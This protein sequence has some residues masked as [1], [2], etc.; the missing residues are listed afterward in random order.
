MRHIWASLT[1]FSTLGLTTVTRGE[2]VQGAYVEARSTPAAASAVLGERSQAVLAWQV[3]QGTY[4]GEKLDGQTIVAVVTG[5]PSPGVN[6]GHTKTVFVVDDRTSE[7]T[8]QAL[9]H[10][11][12]DLATGVIHDAGTTLKSKL[13]VRVAEGCGCGAAVIEC[14]LAKVRT[15]RLTE[16]DEALIGKGLSQKP[17][18]DVFS[19][20]PA[21]AT[22]FTVVG[23]PAPPPGGKTVMTFTGSFSR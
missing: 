5:E 12:R 8:Q 2:S 11:A 1:V 14:P 17:L 19:S 6:F 20:N 4:D 22:E 15:R 9:V 18:G 10:L 16:A 21:W 3:R 7:K 23:E 13:D